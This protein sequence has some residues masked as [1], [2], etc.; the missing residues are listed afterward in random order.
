MTGTPADK[1]TKEWRSKAH[2]AFDPIWK[3]GHMTRSEAY[4]WLARRM[5]SRKLVH[6][7]ELGIN[8]CRRV[9]AVCT[10]FS[11]ANPGRKEAG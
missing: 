3:G 7:G 11:P 6:I 1:H 5:G 10:L 9:I 2:L 4:R 8:G